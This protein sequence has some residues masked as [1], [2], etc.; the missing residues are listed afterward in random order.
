MKFTYCIL[1]MLYA[2]ISWAGAQKTH[3][4]SVGNSMPEVRFTH[5]INAPFSNSTLS[6]PKNK[7]VILDFF[8]TWCG[9][10]INALPHLDSLKKQ[11]G[12][13]LEIWMV[14]QQSSATARAFLETNQKAR[15]VRLPF[16]TGDTV[17]STLFPHRLLPHE[18]WLH[19]GK[20]KAITLPGLVTAANI[21]ALLKGLP[22]C[23]P[24]KQ[25]ILDFNRD[26]PL[27]ENGNGGN[28]ADILYKSTFTRELK[29]VGS[30]QGLIQENDS[31]R[32]YYINRPLLSLYQVAFGFPS[33]RVL[34][35]LKD[36]L[37]CKD[38]DGEPLLFAYEI[39]VPSQTPE[40]QVKTWMAEDLNRQGKLYGSM[41][42]REM[43]C[44]VIAKISEKVLCESKGGKKSVHKD[45]SGN[46]L[47]FTNVPLKRIIDE[48]TH[49]FNPTTVLPIVLDESGIQSNID[50]TIPVSALH[51]ITR[52]K[53][54]LM[55]FGLTL[56]SEVR[57]LDMFILR[58]K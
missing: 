11:M 10:C 18:V 12:D 20:V 42:K 6:Y 14:M 46:H 41:Q 32:W 37:A 54:V 26:I 45:T 56:T 2:C 3:P 8:A 19:E 36:T 23:L 21:R 28:A 17:L 52:L 53:D 22:V 30:M 39:T 44:Y 16:I 15:L 4:L 48:Y 35:E 40:K 51:D 13:S 38:N 5:I 47:V 1:V 33:N 57:E 34:L 7:L 58:D 43:P 31:Q 9:S 50:L 24:L 27:L 25:D 55:P 49:S 29:G